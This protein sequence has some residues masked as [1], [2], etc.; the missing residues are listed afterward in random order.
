LRGQSEP[1]SEF[2]IISIYGTLFAWLF[3]R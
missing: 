1:L 2:K 3:S